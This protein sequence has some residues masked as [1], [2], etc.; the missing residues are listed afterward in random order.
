MY[1]IKDRPIDTDNLNY[2]H[3]PPLKIVLLLKW[4]LCI[5]IPYYSMH[6]ISIH[7]FF[8][9]CW[10]E[11]EVTILSPCTLLSWHSSFFLIYRSQASFCLWSSF[12]RSRKRSNPS[13]RGSRQSPAVPPNS[14]TYWSD[15]FI[16][17]QLLSHFQHIFLSVSFHSA[18]E[19][20]LIYFLFWF[21]FVLLFDKKKK[22]VCL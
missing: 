11:T 15:A 14:L 2:T 4:T 5:L 20:V 6:C 1:I 22:K 7:T 9:V 3:I 19:P 17:H 12:L 13:C 8:S 16:L 21:T 10:A 18:S